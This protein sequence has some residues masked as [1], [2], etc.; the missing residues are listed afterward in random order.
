MLRSR[1]RDRDRV[2]TVMTSNADLKYLTQ[3]QID[4]VRESVGQG[5][6]SLNTCFAFVDS[7]TERGEHLPRPPVDAL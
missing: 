7:S 2:S 1:F 3:E 6:I 4:K 5:F